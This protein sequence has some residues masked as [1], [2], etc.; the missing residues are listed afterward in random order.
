MISDKSWMLSKGCFDGMVQLSPLSVF[1]NKRVF[2]LPSPFVPVVQ[3]T[4]AFYSSVGRPLSSELCP[5]WT[6]SAG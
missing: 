2:G 5:G 1:E 3:G 6:L 4:E